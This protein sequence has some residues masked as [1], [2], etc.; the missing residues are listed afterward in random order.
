MMMRTF[1]S[2]DETTFL[3]GATPAPVP[4]PG[5]P[6][7]HAHPHPTPDTMHGVI[8]PISASIGPELASFCGSATSTPLHRGTTTPSPTVG[9]QFQAGLNLPAALTAT[10]ATSATPASMSVP[11]VGPAVTPSFGSGSPGKALCRSTPSPYARAGMPGVHMGEGVLVALPWTEVTHKTPAGTMQYL[12]TENSTRALGDGASS[13]S[14]TPAG[15][16]DVGPGG[17]GTGSVGSG[18]AAIAGSVGGAG[19][20]AIGLRGTPSVAAGPLSDDLLSP[21]LVTPDVTPRTR[22]WD[23]W[24]TSSSLRQ[25]TPV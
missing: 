22:V 10:S 19:D 7:S 20:G 14:A 8:I 13:I 12:A 25:G 23:T 1:F 3:L 16:G 5:H 2:A 18:F 21:S 24:H 17:F 9:R 6:P 4:V 15:Y 11:P